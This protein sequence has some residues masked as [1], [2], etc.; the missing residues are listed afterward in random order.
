MFIIENIKL[1]DTAGLTTAITS[2]FTSIYGVIN[3]FDNYIKY[4]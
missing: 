4:W 3:N 2:R 1:L